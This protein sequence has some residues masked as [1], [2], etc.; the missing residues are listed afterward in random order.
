MGAAMI[1]SSGLIIIVVVVLV[2]LGTRGGDHAVELQR[3]GDPGT[4]KR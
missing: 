2:L 1:G 3:P 4:R